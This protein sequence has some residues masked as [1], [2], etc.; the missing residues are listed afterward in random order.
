MQLHYLHIWYFRCWAWAQTS[1]LV[2][3]Q[4][5]KPQLNVCVQGVPV[6]QVEGNKLLGFTLDSRL[7]RLKIEQTVAVMSTGLQLF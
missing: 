4:N 5:I 7:T 1:K 3:D 6:E 2:L